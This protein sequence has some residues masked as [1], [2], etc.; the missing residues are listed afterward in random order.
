MLF[1]MGL[2]PANFSIHYVILFVYKSTRADLFYNITN[3]AQLV[4]IPTIC[5]TN[6]QFYR[7]VVQFLNQTTIIYC[8]ISRNPP[9]SSIQDSSLQPCDQIDQTR[10]L[11][12]P[13]SQPHLHKMS[14]IKQTDRNLK[15]RCQHVPMTKVI[16]YTEY[17]ILSSTYQ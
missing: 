1:Q 7:S 4:V 12:Y 13:W 8:P 5:E 15:K 3:S 16:T 17:R 11:S 14:M 6:M 10:P 9:K 2:L